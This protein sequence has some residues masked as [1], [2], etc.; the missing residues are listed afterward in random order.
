MVIVRFQSRSASRGGPVP[1][2][3]P[4][5]DVV[6]RNHVVDSIHKVG[7]ANI[8]DAPSCYVHGGQRILTLYRHTKIHKNAGSIKLAH[9]PPES[10]DPADQ[11]TYELILYYP[12]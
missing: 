7:F 9:N 3:S 1:Q 8:A 12:Q 11:E 2:A 4:A 10:L 6:P 5:V